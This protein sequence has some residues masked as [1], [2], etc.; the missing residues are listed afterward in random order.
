MKDTS[1][2]KWPSTK[3]P[4]STANFKMIGWSWMLLGGCWLLLALPL[5]VGRWLQTNGMATEESWDGTLGAIEVTVF[6]GSVMSGFA[7]L[8]QWRWS[9][10]AIWIVSIIWFSSSLY[11]VWPEQG[12]LS[13]RLVVYGPSLILSVYSATVILIIW[14]RKRQRGRQVQRGMKYVLLLTLG[15]IACVATGALAW[16][17][18]HASEINGTAADNSKS[19]K[20]PETLKELLG[21]RED[22][23]ADA[24]P[25]SHALKG[26]VNSIVLFHCTGFWPSWHHNVTTAVVGLLC[27]GFPRAANELAPAS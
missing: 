14:I 17:Y 25:L 2:M 23:L 18:F 20:Q 27:A 6:V 24:G 16:T 1:I 3:S 22:W 5:I 15:A 12:S 7:L 8:R 19:F 21:L 9:Q 10:V 11:M 4:Q 26:S 13:T